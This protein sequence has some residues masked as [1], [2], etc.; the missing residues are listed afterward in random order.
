MASKVKSIL[1]GALFACALTACG[2]NGTSA[3]PS[4]SPPPAGTASGP[5]TPAWQPITDERLLH[6]ATD[7]GWLMYLRTYS[8]QAHAPF[9]QI[10]THNVAQLH[11]VF[12]HSVSLPEG[13]EA[14]PI[15]NGR[16]MI[17]TTP[18]DHVYALDATNGTQLWE[19]DYDVPKVA[20]RTVCCDVVNRGVAL[21]GGNLYMGTLDNHV[22]ALDAQTGKVVWNVRLQAP[23]IGYAITQAPLVVKGTIIVGDGGGEYGSEQR[24]SAYFVHASHGVK[25]AGAHFP[26]D[27]AFATDFAGWMFG[28]HASSAVRAGASPLSF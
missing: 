24:S 7:D 1:L 21:Y 14:P 22:L 9:A 6:A 28:Q 15:V 11:E 17:V 8:S 3:G 25:A 2:T 16:T 20:L 10:D 4:S 18:M 23:G 13:Y 12:T 5:S 26:L 19:Y 27:G